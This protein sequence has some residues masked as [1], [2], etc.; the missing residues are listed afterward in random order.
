[1]TSSASILRVGRIS[2]E[3]QQADYKQHESY[4]E[5]QDCR[6]CIC[7]CDYDKL[8]PR[9]KLRIFRGWDL[10]MSEDPSAD[11]TVGLTLGVFHFRA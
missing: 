10:V 9:E 8:P 2:L 1:M 6:I 7:A 3:T 11:L 4:R 5:F